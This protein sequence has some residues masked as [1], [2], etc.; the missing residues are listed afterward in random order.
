[1]TQR[2]ILN[3]AYLAALDIW[4]KENEIAKNLPRNEFSLARAE[5]AYE[6]VEYIGKLL[7]KEEHK[8][9]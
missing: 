6:D 7:Y 1:M 9:D 4:A 8:E 5:K 3:L 2:K